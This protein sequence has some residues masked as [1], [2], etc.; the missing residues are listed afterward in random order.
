MEKIKNKNKIAFLRRNVVALE[1]NVPT[2]LFPFP[3]L[4]GRVEEH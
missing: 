3:S 2:D 1:R 4:V